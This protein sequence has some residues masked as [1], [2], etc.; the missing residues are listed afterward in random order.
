MEQAKNES[1]FNPV[2]LPA[3]TLTDDTHSTPWK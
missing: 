1:V 2:Y 3:G